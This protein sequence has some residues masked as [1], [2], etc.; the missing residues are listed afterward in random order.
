MFVRLAGCNIGAKED[1]KWCDTAFA[2][3][4]ATL[5]T[6]DA[7]LK[8]IGCH[9]QAR[10]VV[11]TGGEPMLQWRTLL[12]ILRTLK[13]HKPGLI[14]QM[15]TN[16]MLIRAEHIDAFREVGMHVV[17][18][19][20]IAHN[21][22]IYS[23][24]PIYRLWHPRDVRDSTCYF[25]YVVSAD[26]NSDYHYLSGEAGTLF[27]MGFTV[28]VSGMTAYKRAPLDG[29]VPN[30]W[31]TDLVDH[32]ETAANYA[33]AARVALEHGFNVSYQSHLFGNVQ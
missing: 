2:F 10:V 24:W 28:F 33:H 5:T 23:T 27:Q 30:V 18:S 20:K 4:T 15:E 9:P 14:F 1:C 26:R 17:V 31:N 19:P 6:G 32:Y 13:R 3:D 7:L 22:G 16:G 12:P 8:A 21:K 11:F 29:E 25:K